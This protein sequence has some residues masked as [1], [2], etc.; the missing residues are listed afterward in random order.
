M[1][2]KNKKGWCKETEILVLGFGGAGGVAAIT[3]CD[4]GSEVTIL[5][6][7][8]AQTHITNTGMSAGV[9]IVVNDVA[10]AVTYMEHLY[11]VGDH[12]HWTDRE[13]IQIWAEYCTE[14]TQWLAGIGGR[15]SMFGFGGEHHHVPGCEAIEMHVQAGMGPGLQKLL[16]KAVEARGIAVSYGTRAKKILTNTQGKVIGVLAEQEGREVT[17]R[18]S[19]AVIMATGGFEFDEDMKLNYLKVHPSYFGGTPANTGDGI[20]MAQDVGASL[21]HMNCCSA[22]LVGKFPGVP[23]ATYLD[24]GGK[25]LF[26]RMQK[27]AR[28]GF[29]SPFIIVDKYG[30]RFTN[31]GEIKTHSLYYELATYDSQLLDYPRVPCYL[32]FDLTRLNASPL[33]VPWAKYFYAWSKDNLAELEKGWIVQGES[34]SELSLRLKMEPAI[35]KRTVRNYNRYCEQGEDPEFHRPPQ[36][37]KPLNNAPF[38]AV[39]L[40]PG[41]PNTQG[42]PCRNARAQVLNV[43]GKPI[44][45]LYAAGELGSIYGMI[46]P[47][48]GGNI[49]ECIAFGRIAGEQAAKEIP[50]S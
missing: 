27:I 7:Q 5:E 8:P 19:R 41:G 10:K 30:R 40:W 23:N 12:L 48:G 26:S 14:N 29:F 36:H 31:D 4:A 46:Y 16:E 18:A 42:G 37:L 50:I 3:A 11:S 34:L 47:A 20:R 9:Y 24:F 17:F 38:F 28:E 44:P 32:I 25:L 15:M 39:P 21:W 49:A 33:P 43:D 6:K 2:V 1:L 13:T 22:R 45:R 35:L